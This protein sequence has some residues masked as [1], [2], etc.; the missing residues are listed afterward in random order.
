MKTKGFELPIPDE[1]VVSML[2]ISAVADNQHS[3]IKLRRW[4]ILFKE[5]TALIKR[6]GEMICIDSHRDWTLSGDGDLKLLFCHPERITLLIICFHWDTLS[7]SSSP[8]GNSTNPL[9]VAPT[10]SILKWHTSSCKQRFISQISISHSIPLH[11]QLLYD[12]RDEV[13]S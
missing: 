2:R 13:Y 11:W 5:N 10:F 1:P 6:E 12:G 3:V 7:F 9:S 4:A 8:E